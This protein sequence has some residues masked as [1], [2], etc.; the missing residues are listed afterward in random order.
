MSR[1]DPNEMSAAGGTVSD[2]AANSA[3]TWIY[4]RAAGGLLAKVNTRLKAKM[5]TAVISMMAD[6]GSHDQ[7]DLANP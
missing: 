1:H 7:A 4:G 5:A 6:A 3:R 2:G